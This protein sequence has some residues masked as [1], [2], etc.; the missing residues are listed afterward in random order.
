MRLTFLAVTLFLFMLF[1]YGC[2]GGGDTISTVPSVNNPSD[3]NPSDTVNGEGSILVRADWPKA[4]PEKA[5]SILDQIISTGSVQIEGDNLTA[6]VIPNSAVRILVRVQTTGNFTLKEGE[7]KSPD[8]HLLLTGLPTNQKLQIIFIAYD[9][10][11]VIVSHRISIRTLTGGLLTTTVQLGV[12]I[13]GNLPATQLIPSTLAVHPGDVV[14][15]GGRVTGVPCTIVV[16]DPGG[17]VTLNMPGFDINNPNASTVKYTTPSN[18]SANITYDVTVDPNGTALP[19]SGTLVLDTLPYHDPNSAKDVTLPYNTTG[20]ILA[21]GLDDYYR[22][23]IPGNTHFR[24]VLDYPYSGGVW[25]PNQDLDLYLVSSDPNHTV[26]YPSEGQGTREII[27]WPLTAGTYYVAVHGYHGAVNGYTLDMTTYSPGATYQRQWGSLGTGNG[28]FYYPMG[29]VIDSNNDVYVADYNNN[30]VQ[31]FN[32]AGTYISKFGT[33]GTGNGQFN[34]PAGVAVDSADNVYVTDYKNNRVQK[35]NSVGTYLTQWGVVGA[36]NSQFDQPYGI[37]IDASDNVYVSD[38]GNN[39]VQ[40]FDSAGTYL[41]QWGTSGAGNGQFNGP[42]GV[43]VDPNGLIY[44]V[45]TNNSRI[46]IFDA[47][48]VYDSQWGTAGAGDAQ[49]QMPTNVLCTSD[50]IFV[51]DSGN[52]NIKIF[53]YSKTFERKWGGR[54]KDMF[55]DPAE[56]FTGAPFGIGTDNAGDVYISN[57]GGHKVKVFNP[58]FP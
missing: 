14:S 1:L 35:F 53:D 32:S 55:T 23:T 40:K 34:N 41:L 51:V 19:L 6:Q 25:D 33:Q 45:D 12:T 20:D 42:C 58:I 43:A 37:A 36:G 5:S 54:G 21:S 31:K 38:E 50:G 39:R 46:Q 56:I 8:R 24:A 47:L 29:T 57:T 22:F 27:D 16:H 17:D 4:A 9:N 48:G 7:I 11:D 30:R 2:G 3:T 52:Y 13:R 49:F 44:V 28:Q 18:M 10:A 26:I 15:W